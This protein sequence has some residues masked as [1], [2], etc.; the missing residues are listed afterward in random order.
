MPAGCQFK[1]GLAERRVQSIKKTLN[2]M[3]ATTL[4][5]GKLTLHCAEL[6]TILAR[7]ANI[8]NNWPIGVRSLTEEDIVPITVNQLL[9][10]R[11]LTSTPGALVGVSEDFLAANSF[12]EEAGTTR[13]R[14]SRSSLWAFRGWS[15]SVLPRS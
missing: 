13:L 6:Q 15:F 7:A 12:Q 8:I 1:I 4:V 5:G 3:L 11:T 14:P 10:G 2:H 9:L